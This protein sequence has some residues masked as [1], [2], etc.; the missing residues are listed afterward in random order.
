[1]SDTDSVSA[2]TLEFEVFE[3]ACQLGIF[4]Q[5]RLATYHVQQ[6]DELTAKGLIRVERQA[7]PLEQRLILGQKVSVTLPDHK[8]KAVDSRWQLLWENSDFLVVY[9]PHLLPV[10]RTTRNL[11]N[12]LI[13]LVRRQTPYADAQ[14]LHRL[15]S[16]TAGIIVL[17]KHKAVAK[18]FQPQLAELIQNKTYHAWVWGQPVWR[19]L[20][21]QCELAEKHNSPI[22]CQMFVVDETHQERFKTPKYARSWFQYVRSTAQMSLITCRIFTGRKHQIRAHLASVGHPIVGDK[23]YAHQGEFYLKRLQG[24]L[25][26][27][28][29][30]ALKSPYQRLVATAIDLFVDGETLALELPPALLDQALQP[31][32]DP[33]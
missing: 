11:Y 16:E 30:Q 1:M 13:S 19:E 12:T 27:Q 9:K 7:A 17:G 28:D 6:L 3:S 25:H 23:I 21:L 26:R 8:E 10:S 32:S 4:L 15:D 18:K 29:Y 24:P 33:C 22:R 20:D 5:S 2:F 14:L 31:P